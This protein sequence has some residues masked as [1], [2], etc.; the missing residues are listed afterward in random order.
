MPRK[1]FDT[2]R[3]CRLNGKSPTAREKWRAFHRLYRLAHGR[4]GYQDLA[5]AE[6][7][8][9]LYSDWRPVQ[10]L[11]GGTNDGRVNTARVPVVIRKRLLA[12]RRKQWLYGGNRELVERDKAVAATLRAEGKEITPLEVAVVRKNVVR[13]AREKA[14]AVGVVLPADDAAVLRMMTSLRAEG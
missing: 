9:V 2:E 6:C 4:G 5:A 14:A 11:E 8:R 10:L 1:E 13:I 3:L 7:F 12:H